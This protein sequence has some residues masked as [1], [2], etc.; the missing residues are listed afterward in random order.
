MK[1]IATLIVERVLV[2]CAA[3]EAS[4]E[5][6][7]EE[8]IDPVTGAEAAT[9]GGS[10]GGLIG[11]TSGAARAQRRWT[12]NLKRL[13][14]RTPADALRRIGPGDLGALSK[15][16]R[17]GAVRGGL[18]LGALGAG[19]GYGLQRLLGQDSESGE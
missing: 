7:D 13:G 14:S 10:L 6:L 19:A 11:G 1:K 2:K 12:E 15:S 3:L 4:E 18:G 17:R 16:M 8:V 9:F 5:Q